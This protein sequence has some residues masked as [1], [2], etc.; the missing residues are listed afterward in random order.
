MRGLKKS[1][2]AWILSKSFSDWPPDDYVHHHY[3]KNIC[4]AAKNLLSELAGSEEEH[5]KDFESNTQE[6]NFSDFQETLFLW[7]E[8]INTPDFLNKC[9]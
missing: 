2:H 9:M 3:I 5:G 6:T 1:R 4:K 7:K 8:N